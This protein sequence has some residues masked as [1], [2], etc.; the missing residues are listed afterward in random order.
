LKLY[1]GELSILLHRIGAVEM[2][3]INVEE[4]K[5]KAR[6][7]IIEGISFDEIMSETRLRLKDLKRIQRDIAE[8]L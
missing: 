5:K 6:D 7:M 4:A 1:K 8:K 3:E 2:E